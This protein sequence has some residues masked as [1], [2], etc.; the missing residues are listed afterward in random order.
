MRN[1]PRHRIQRQTPAEVPRNMASL[2]AD[3]TFHENA[4]SGLTV[5]PGALYR[6]TV[7]YYKNDTDPGRKTTPSTWLAMR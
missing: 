3:Y 5:G 4:L 1:T 6:L 7:S 2:W